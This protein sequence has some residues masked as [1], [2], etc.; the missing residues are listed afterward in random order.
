MWKVKAIWVAVFVSLNFLGE[1]IQIQGARHEL[2]GKYRKLIALNKAKSELHDIFQ[3]QELN[4]TVA[5]H[6]KVLQG[7]K[8][9]QEAGT[10]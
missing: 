3:T 1:Y 7:L 5:Q 6:S 9:L 4:Y 2:D 10:P 8:V